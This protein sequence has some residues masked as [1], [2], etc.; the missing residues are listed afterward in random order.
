MKILFKKFL[1]FL[2]YLLFFNINCF[3]LKAQ[4]YFRKIDTIY[5]VFYKEFEKIISFKDAT[6]PYNDFLPYYTEKFF[7][8]PDKYTLILEPLK[9]DKINFSINEAIFKRIPDTI[10]YK[11]HKIYE[12][13]NFTYIIE[14]MPLLKT[15]T[16][17]IIYLKEFNIRF[18]EEA[19]IIN[20]KEG[21]K[22]KISFK[23]NS[24]LREGRWVKIKLARDGVYKLT[25]EQLKSL[26]FTNLENIKVYGNGGMQLPYNFNENY[27]DDLEELPIMYI[28][29]SDN[30]FNDGDFIIF[31]GKGTTRW[32][33]DS[34]KEMFFQKLHNYSDYAYYFITDYGGQPKIIN[35]VNYNHLEYNYLTNE[36]DGCAYYEKELINLSKGGRLFLSES[37]DFELSKSYSFVF[38][39]II[40]DSNL[41]LFV[42][43]GANS[44]TSSS[45]SVYINNTFV[46]N[47]NLSPI[48]GSLNQ[49]YAIL[50][51][52]YSKIK[53]NSNSITVKLIYNKPPIGGVGYLDFITLNTREFIEYKGFPL[54]FRDIK[55]VDSNRITKYLIKTI[56]KNIYIWDI[57]NPVYPLNV[58]FFSEDNNIS[59]IYPSESLKE[60]IIFSYN[61]LLVPEIVGIIP[62]QN[63]HSLSNIDMII[64]TQKEFMNVCEELCELHNSKENLNCIVLT[65]ELIYNEFSSGI[66]DASAIR[67]LCKMLYEK[68]LIKYPKYLLLFGDGSYD[69]RSYINKKLP[70]YQSN[71]QV[72]DMLSGIT[73]DDYFVMLDDNEY[74]Y[75]GSLDMSVGRIPVNN[76]TEATNVVNK[77]KNYYSLN[78]LGNWKNYLTFIADDEDGNEYVKESEY[79]TNFIDTTA[80][81]YIID[82]IYLDAHKQESTPIGHRYPT[83][84]E[85]IK[86]RINKGTFYVNYIGHGN[87]YGL[88]HEK[89]LLVSD[90]MDFK[91]INS[92]FLFFAA[93]CEFGRW[94]DHSLIS[95]GEHLFLNKNGGSIAL[96]S[97]SRPVFA[98]SNFLL[99]KQFILALFSE[100]SLNK[101]LTIG[102]VFRIAKNNTGGPS[103]LN[104]RNFSLIGDPALTL[105]F[106]DYN[107]LI[108]S[109]NNKSILD[110]TDTIKPLSIV[111]IKGRILDSNMIVS[112]FNGIVF[113]DL[114]DKPKKMST[115]GNDGGQTLAFKIQTNSIFKGLASVNAGEFKFKFLVP[116]DISYQ[117][118][119]LKIN[120][121]AFDSLIKKDATGYYDKLIVGGD[122][123]LISDS[124]GPNI[125]IYLNDLIFSE[126]MITNENPKLIVFLED[127]NGINISNN[128]IGNGIYLIL[129]KLNKKILLNDYFISEINDFRKG[130]VEYFLQNLPEGENI[131]IIEASD[132]LN[133]KSRKQVKFNVIKKEIVTI[134]SVYNYPNPFSSNTVFILNHNQAYE[135]LEVIIDI[136]NINGKLIKRINDFVVP[137]GNITIIGNWDGKDMFGNEVAN[138]LYFYRLRIKTKYGQTEKFGKMVKL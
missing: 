81:Q 62:N 16:N 127:E 86:K 3:F 98:N 5:Y 75:Y 88:A 11:V 43:V 72:P 51:S 124:I 122:P 137:N 32:I 138:G 40:P 82:K 68:D 41:K 6:Y 17:E 119:F 80:K 74:E 39:S 8:I 67:Y 70:T 117:N 2:I 96:L 35:T 21:L 132:L 126:N 92:L 90:I 123:I 99:N 45:F 135:N 133:N 116:K 9:W 114:L 47:I 55:S 65:P 118:D 28:R 130:K 100:Q 104:K 12:N 59:F 125:K 24:V 52:L 105:A 94:D 46:G 61:D 113:I 66:P 20:K 115:L 34:Q 7:N 106:P 22:N 136:F 97:A 108:D 110:F 101:K 42:R 58:E 53:V 50:N 19:N 77:I 25:Y 54:V 107:I 29:G 73:T 1:T 64:V 4:V 103:D 15:K 131:I 84:T 36:F 63:L 38:N 49:N 112:N 60:F 128:S 121:Y 26:G 71:N 120:L 37:F 56:N 129:P 18:Q 23:N 87:E 91:N 10:T 89:V 27:I 102:D 85:A 78:S 69:N 93:T 33:Y 111:E 57:T 14:L 95:A 109:I 44:P 31:Y 83:V 13:K 48:V 30:V 134:N 79:L 76:L